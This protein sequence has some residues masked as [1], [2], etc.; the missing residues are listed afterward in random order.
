MIKKKFASTTLLLSV[1]IKF[2]KNTNIKSGAQL[3]YLENSAF[4]ANVITIYIRCLHLHENFTNCTKKI[5]ILI[6]V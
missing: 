6:T 3:G 4:N 5:T 1:S 2:N